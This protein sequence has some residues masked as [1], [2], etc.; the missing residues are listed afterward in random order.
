MVKSLYSSM[1]D[2]ACSFG[3]VGGDGH[4]LEGVAAVR[5]V[6]ARG[7]QTGPGDPGLGGRHG[8]DLRARR[9]G[10]RRACVWATNALTLAAEAA[11][12]A[13]ELVA[14]RVVALDLVEHAL[15]DDAPDLF[16]APLRRQLFEV[17]V[18][19]HDLVEGDADEEH[20]APDVLEVGVGPGDELVD[21]DVA[22]G[23]HPEEPEVRVRPEPEV[24]GGLGQEL[25]LEEP[26]IVL[27]GRD[28]LGDLGLEAVLG[29][30]GGGQGGS[31]GPV[32]LDDRRGSA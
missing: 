30:G 3:P 15:D 23:R 18:G 7:D 5:F 31:F 16:L 2:V 22:L 10:R 32:E 28:D 12:F 25:V 26:L 17:D 8:H 14:G 29:G 20:L 21:R 19:V 24:A 11:I 9:R 1:K 13:D 27:E 4:D 6:G